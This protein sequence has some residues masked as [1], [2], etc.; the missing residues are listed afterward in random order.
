MGP[1]KRVIGFENSPQ[2]AP[3]LRKGTLY[4]A[5]GPVHPALHHA[6]SSHKASTPHHMLASVARSVNK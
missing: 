5:S 3:R 1:G 2:A 6:V 4:C